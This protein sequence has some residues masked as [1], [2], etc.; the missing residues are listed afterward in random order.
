M[1]D[2]SKYLVS[3]CVLADGCRRGRACAG[4]QGGGGRIRRRAAS[5][6]GRRDPFPEQ[7]ARRAIIVLLFYGQNTEYCFSFLQI[8]ETRLKR[9][10]FYFHINP[11]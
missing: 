2:G 6:S 7:E 5:C 1:G 9:F 11:T 10:L 4:P 3:V 8:K